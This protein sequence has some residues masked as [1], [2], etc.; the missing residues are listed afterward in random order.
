VTEDHSRYST[1]LLWSEEDACWEASHPELPGCTAYGDTPVDALNEL[2]NLRAEW[3]ETAKEVGRPVPPPVTERYT[4]KF[5]V[6]IP[7]SLHRH[8]AA[9]AKAEGVSI[10]HLVTHL[11][12]Q[13]LGEVRFNPEL[14]II[15]QSISVV[16][17]TFSMEEWQSDGTLLQGVNAPRLLSEAGRA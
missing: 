13:G 2:A 11:L 4:G 5:T 10:N 3:L 12:S 17:P 7:R 14:R 9:R 6:R 16:A 1:V 15:M 8:L